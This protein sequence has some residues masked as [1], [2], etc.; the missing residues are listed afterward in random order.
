VRR[1]PIRP[2]F[3]AIQLTE[4]DLMPARRRLTR[5]ITILVLAALAGAV[6]WRVYALVAAPAGRGSG[7]GTGGMPVTLDAVRAVRRSMPLVIESPGTVQTE[8]TVTVRAQVGGTLEKVLFDEGDEVKA[9]QLLFVID[10]AL[11]KIAVAQNEGQVEQDKAKLGSDRAN[12]DR[13]AKL[14]KSGYVS[15]QDYQNAT[16]LVQQDEGTLAADGARLDQA[17]LDLSYTEIRAPIAGKTGALAYKTGNLIQTND[18]TPLVT[19]NQIAPIQVQ[20]D[21]PQSQLGAL[22]EH[23]EDPALEVDVHGPDGRTIATD[24]KLVFIDNAINESAGTLSLKAEFSNADRG[25]W[26]GELVTVDLTLTREPDALVIPAIAVQPGQDGGYVYVIDDGRVAVRNVQ[27]EREY[28]G[29]AVISRGLETGD[30]VVVHVPRE[31]REGQPAMAKLLPAA[32]TASAPGDA[33]S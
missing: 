1:T 32:A 30:I 29:R 20:F 24:G 9:G 10:P 15:T 18:T 33:T 2:A 22:L 27:V 3:A 13:M 12:A 6:A 11:Y 14:V 16:A 23:R 25:L 7:P 4:N 21:I 8:H 31:L 19:I 17:K 28:G 5:S 26:P